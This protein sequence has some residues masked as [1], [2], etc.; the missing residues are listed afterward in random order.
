MN[1]PISTI[2]ILSEAFI[3]AK[4]SIMCK[5]ND[6]LLETFII[7]DLMTISCYSTVPRVS[8]CH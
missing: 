6:I 2:F 4:F 7:I 8:Y 3:N 5:I 1:Y